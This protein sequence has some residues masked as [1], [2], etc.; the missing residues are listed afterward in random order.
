MSMHT[1]VYLHAHVYTHIGFLPVC[2]AR[3]VLER[4][5]CDNESKAKTEPP[6]LIMSS[7][8]LEKRWGP[9]FSMTRLNC[10]RWYFCKCSPKD[11]MDYRIRGGA[12]CNRF[13]LNFMKSR[14]TTKNYLLLLAMQTDFHSA[15]IME[16][17]QDFVRSLKKLALHKHF[18]DPTE[19][20]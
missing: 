19:Q 5:S 17:I 4:A 2:L 11:W 3:D 6:K 14:H 9:G 7:L 13:L 8:A 18:P 20:I 15:V 1:H 10:K 12:H 16:D